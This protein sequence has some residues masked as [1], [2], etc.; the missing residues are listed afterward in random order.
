[1]KAMTMTM[2][3]DHSTHQG[4]RSGW[5]RAALRVLAAWALVFGISTATAAGPSVGLMEL[6]VP[7][8]DG[9]IN[10]FYP[11]TDVEQPLHRG[12]FTLPF[13]FDGTLAPG[14]GRLIVI[15]HGSGGAAWVHT[16]LARRLVDAGFVVAV[17]L[18]HADN[19]IDPSNPGPDSWTLRPA[20]ISRAI[21][22]VG[23]EPRLSTA[24]LK[25][26]R[27]GVYGMSAGGH[28][29]LSLAGGRWSPA[30]FQRH[31]DEDLADD[32]Q[33][34]VGLITRL[35]GGIL[36]PIKLAA[37]RGVIASRFGDD[38]LRDDHDPR[39]A[40]IVAAVPAAADF[41]PASLV[42]PRVPLGL[43]T[44]DH[45]RWLVP[46]F[47][48]DAV[49]KVCTRCE[50]L[51]RLPTGGHGALLSPLPPG[52][53]GLIGDLLNDPP[54]F[55]RTTELPEVDRRIVDFFARHLLP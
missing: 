55:D 54:G 14:N 30:R 39:V 42:A 15:S 23:R 4:L 52:L 48:A 53:D 9:P 29:A 45:D 13:A 38:R 18:H 36:D 28:T 21:D 5:A 40:A 37:A 6:A 31:C 10:V 24:A 17:P 22:A 12:R 44:A 1:M 51:A 34:C 50:R 47:H 33:F 25:F 2:T 49:L 26:D 19:A 43:V 16:A 3:T 27:V 32:F 7:G 8:N 20:E 41:D 11:S 46:R 35:T